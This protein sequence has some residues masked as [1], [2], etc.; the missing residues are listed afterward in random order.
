MY[1]TGING[2]SQGSVRRG[3]YATYLDIDHSD[4]EE[5]LKIKAEGND[6]QNLNFGLCVPDYWMKEMIAGDRHKQTLWG[7]V[8]Q[9]KFETGFPYIF[10][11]GNANK[12]APQVYKDKGMTIWASNLCTEIMLATSKEESFVCDLGHI[13]LSK[14]NEIKSEPLGLDDVFEVLSW[15]LDA[16]MTEFIR[17]SEGCHQLDKARRFAINQRAI[18]VGVV[19]YHSYLQQ[20]NIAYESMEAKFINKEIFSTMRKSLDKSSRKLAAILGEPPLLKGY[21]IRWVTNMTIAPTTSSSFILGQIT[22]AA[23]PSMSNYFTKDL[24]KGKFTFKSPTLTKVLKSYGKDTKDVW[25]SILTHG[26]SAQ[27]LD[28]L[29]QHERNVYKTCQEIS[30]MEIV[31]QAAQ[32]QPDIDQGQSLNLV[33]ASDTPA[34]EV[35]KVLIYGWEHGIKSFYYQRGTNPAQE[36]ARNISS[37]ASCEG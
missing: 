30:Q 24:A 27:H 36:I 9:K 7:K 10:F 17:K 4:V 22:P 5:F 25:K 16:V 33:F 14:W 21:G 37:C 2:V 8:I 28:F 12:T 15:H 6:I 13:N 29:T 18:G 26:G 34:R 23:D 11:S 20:E 32:R 3:A 35:N 1:D 31:V 19:G